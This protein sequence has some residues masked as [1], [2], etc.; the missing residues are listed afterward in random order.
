MA[1]GHPFFL[2]S[3]MWASACLHRSLHRATEA[4][5]LA[6]SSGSDRRDV[7]QVA[8]LHVHQ[9]LPQD[10]ASYFYAGAATTL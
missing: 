9:T 7:K 1:F 10:A 8:V 2:F 6:I 5:P 4:F 3:R